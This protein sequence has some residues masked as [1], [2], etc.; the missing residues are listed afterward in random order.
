MK[1]LRRLPSTRQSG[2]MPVVSGAA[3][4]SG[5]STGLKPQASAAAG[6]GA[7]AV[8]QTGGEGEGP[9]GGTG[10]DQP[11][12][13]GLGHEG[14]NCPVPGRPLAEMREQG[15]RRIPAARHSEQ[16]DRQAGRR[17]IRARI[18]TARRR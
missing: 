8:G 2:S 10:R 5:Q 4:G 7:H 11:A 17:A 9:G 1:I 6:A 13:P 18:S 14:G 12:L 16:I 15:K 3:S